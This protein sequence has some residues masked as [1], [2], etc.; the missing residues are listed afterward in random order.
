MWTLL[1]LVALTGPL[2]GVARTSTIVVPTSLVVGAA[3]SE[4]PALSTDS[5]TT[6]AE[7]T[8]SVTEVTKVTRRSATDRPT[9]GLTHS[10][11][12][13]PTQSPTNSAFITEEESDTPSITVR[14]G[15]T[16]S[17]AFPEEPPS[18]TH[19]SAAPETEV[20]EKLG[21]TPTVLLEETEGALTIGQVAGIAIGALLALAVVV[22]IVAMAVRRMGQYSP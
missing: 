4:M 5:Q 21:L 16:E 14:S 3:A 12:K 22:A 20:K 19:S 10:P 18:T 11:T 7:M 13:G 6:K 8:E 2:C 1:L 9:E 15:V 17:P